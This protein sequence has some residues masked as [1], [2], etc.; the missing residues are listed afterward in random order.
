MLDSTS[1]GSGRLFDWS[2][3]DEAPAGLS[4]D[5]VGE[6]IERVWPWGVDVASGIEI[7]P[8][9]KDPALVQR[10]VRAAKAA[11]RG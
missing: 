5:N 2:L 11:D 3:A 9:V 8:G 4:P 10:F 6:A 7:V 1:P